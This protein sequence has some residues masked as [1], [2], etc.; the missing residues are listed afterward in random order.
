MNAYLHGYLTMKF[1]IKMLNIT[2]RDK[3]RHGDIIQMGIE[4]SP[5]FVEEQRIMWLG[6]FTRMGLKIQHNIQLIQTRRRPRKR[7]KD[8]VEKT[9]L[10]SNVTI[11][12]ATHLF[13]FE[14]ASALDTLNCERGQK[15]KQ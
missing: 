4:S 8:V 14:K 5:C 11:Q 7:W 13:T 12:N 15:S 1:L 2:R 9:I 3:E 10:R 6:L